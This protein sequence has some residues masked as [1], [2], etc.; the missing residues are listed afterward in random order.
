MSV[1]NLKGSFHVHHVIRVLLKVFRNVNKYKFK[2]ALRT[3]YT[4]ASKLRG[5]ESWL[6]ANLFLVKFEI[7]LYKVNLNA[8][9]LYSADNKN[10]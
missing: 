1:Q 9:V 2:Q 6:L 8:N 3:S 5:D 4:N 10:V 7:L